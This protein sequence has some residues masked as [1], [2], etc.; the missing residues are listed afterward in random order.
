MSD[1]RRQTIAHM[2]RMLSATAV[3]GVSMGAEA[4]DAQPKTSGSDA[5][6]TVGEGEW[7]MKNA[8]PDAGGPNSGNIG[9]GVVDPMPEP[10]RNR[11][12]GCHKSD[13]YE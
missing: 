2:R 6:P 12:C 9:Y 4:Q 8:N 11:G 5:G 10:A 13:P 7:H 3:V 1:A